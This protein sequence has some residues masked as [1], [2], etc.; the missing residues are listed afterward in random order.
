MTGEN[1]TKAKLL[2]VDRGLGLMVVKR[3][4]LTPFFNIVKF[5]YESTPYREISI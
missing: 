2:V 3:S 1:M 4:L 5:E